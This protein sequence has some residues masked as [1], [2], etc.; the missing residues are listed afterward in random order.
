MDHMV[1]GIIFWVSYLFFRS[2]AWHIFEVNWKE[3]SGNI[4]ILY[5]SSWVP[6]FI[7][8]NLS[9]ILKNIKCIRHTPRLIVK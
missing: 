4:G 3:L 1:E 9:N 6:Y 8:G 7:R 2:C 5:E